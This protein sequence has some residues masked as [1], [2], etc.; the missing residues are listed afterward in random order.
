MSEQTYPRHSF[1]ASWPDMSPEEFQ[2][3][4]DRIMVNGLRDP[5]VLYEGQILDGWQRYQA[6]LAECVEPRF[7]V[8]EG[9]DDDAIDFVNDKHAR[10]SLTMTQRLAC[11]ATMM[12]FR[13]RGRPNKS[14][15]FAD[16]S[17]QP[18]TADSPAEKTVTEL[19]AMA[20]SSVRAA[21]SVRAALEHG[22][23]EVQDG[24]RTG[25]LPAY[26]AEQIA[27]LP[28][29]EQ[30]KAVEE[31]KAPKPKKAKAAPKAKEPD[32]EKS[33]GRGDEQAPASEIEALRE[34]NRTLHEA[35]AALQEENELLRR[36]VEA[37]DPLQA[38]VAAAAK[39]QEEARG[40]YART[41]SQT[42]QIAELQRSVNWWK[43]KAEQSA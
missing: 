35:I 17:A 10:R 3:L 22:T 36:V 14:A 31:A 30:P 42:A 26:K 37:D 7:E 16:L 39:A 2:A 32:D 11:I 8:F 20:G 29:Q 5:I 24:M 33:T 41:Q 6:C 28:P 12:S 25:A 18:S 21:A 19:A 34:E 15:N 4:R 43:K 27:K 23:P 1:S 40:H 38:A 9:A 13:G